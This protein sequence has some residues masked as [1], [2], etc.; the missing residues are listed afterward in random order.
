[1]RGVQVNRRVFL[2][3]ATATAV[4]AFAPPSHAEGDSGTPEYQ[5]LETF[6][7]SIADPSVFS[8]GV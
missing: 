7:M 5:S 2:A 8:A 6:L 3:A 1:M 4:L